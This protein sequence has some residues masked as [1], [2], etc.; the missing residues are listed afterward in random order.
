MMNAGK[1][2]KDIKNG[3]QKLSKKEGKG[4]RHLFSTFNPYLSPR[5]LRRAWIEKGPPDQRTVDQP[6]L[7]Q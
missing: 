5:F 6:G 3:K 7:D 2:M 1:R 4:V